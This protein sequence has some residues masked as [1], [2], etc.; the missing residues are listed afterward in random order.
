MTRSLLLTALFAIVATAFTPCAAQTPEGDALSTLRG[1]VL[2]A[3]SGATLG[4][5]GS[6][7]PCNRTLLGH[8]CALVGASAGGVV[9]LTV[10]GIMGAEDER[11]VRAR[12]EHAGVGALIGAVA[13]LVLRR[14]VRQYGWADV[15]AMSALG[16]AI[17]ASA[18]GAGLG[19]GIG[20]ATG[21]V[22]WKIFPKAGIQDLFL[23]T[24]AGTAL[25][26]L[27]DWADGAASA[28]GSGG[29]PGP[30][31]SIPVR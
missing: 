17:G 13:G 20:A 12:F 11:A 16:G 4:L 28:R 29:V 31:F 15:A 7:L 5:L 19:A 3:S 1:A 23:F 24:L 9:G 14:G 18:R 30:S 26:G 22:V 25:G 10:G 2:G 27:Y 21:A 6:L 8:R